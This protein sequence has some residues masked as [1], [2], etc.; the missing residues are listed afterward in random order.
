MLGGDVDLLGIAL[1]RTG[2]VQHVLHTASFTV[3]GVG[4]RAEAARMHGGDA[5]LG[6]VAVTVVQEQVDVLGAERYQ[7]ESVRQHLIVQRT[8]V[9]V[10]GHQ[11]DGHD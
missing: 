8:V 1:H 4:A 7:S 2:Y 6:T 11:V 9:D 10:D 3:G 5:R